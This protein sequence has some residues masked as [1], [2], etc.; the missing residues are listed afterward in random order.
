MYYIKSVS[1]FLQLKSWM[2][3][4]ISDDNCRLLNEA[5]HAPPLRH[6][7]DVDMDF[8]HQV[9]VIVLSILTDNFGFNNGFQPCFLLHETNVNALFSH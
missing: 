3:F 1:F 7:N 2:L 4:Q 5:L 8:N 6:M 9:S